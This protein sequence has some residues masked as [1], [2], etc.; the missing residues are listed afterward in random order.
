[1]QDKI[2]QGGKIPAN[3]KAAILAKGY[4]QNRLAEEAKISYVTISRY[5]SG[6][7]IPG[8]ME[9]YRMAQAL[10]TS[11]EMILTG[12]QKEADSIWKERAERAEKKL[13][14]L[15]KLVTRYARV[16]SDLGE[17]N[18]MLAEALTEE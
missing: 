14:Q 15:Q 10:D 9:L 1:M 2:L 12:E 6:E 7:R 3:L 13:A 5:M 16:H 17:L 4:N 8:T 11:M 18:V